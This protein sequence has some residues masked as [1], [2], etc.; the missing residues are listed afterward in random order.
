MPS[1]LS[2]TRPR[3]RR[4][5]V[6]VVTGATAGLGR[7]VARE[8]AGRARAV[9]VLGRGHDGLAA[10]VAEVA[11]RG[12]EPLALAVDVADAAAVDDAAREIESFLGPIEVWV[13]NAMASVFA[14]FRSMDL[15]EFHRAV[16]VDFFG[17]V[18]GTRSALDRMVP[19]DRGVVVQVGSALAY[20]SIPL[21]SAYCSAKHAVVGFTE[22]LR[23]ELLHDGSKVRVTMVQMPALNTPQFDMVRSRL[24][25]RARPVAP[26][27]QPEVGARAVAFAAAHPGRRNYLVGASTLLTVAANQVVPGVLDHYLART[28]YQAQQ[29]DQ[30]EQPGRPDDLLAPVPGDH[31]AHGRFDQEAHAHSLQFWCSAHR[32]ALSAGAVGA[33]AAALS[34]RRGVG[35]RP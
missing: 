6:V 23:T 21:Q 13:N 1:L 35:R 28:G 12:A 3:P 26:V 29:T 19:R 2:R 9:A 7:A 30:P 20:R 5:G 14:P 33:A 34:V 18:H 17:Y 27:Y 31:G 16:E 32:R 22:S 8:M 25:G 24:A 10:V 15:E 4:H 11:G